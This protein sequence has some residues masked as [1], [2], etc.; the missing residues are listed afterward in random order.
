MFKNYQGFERMINFSFKVAAESRA[1]LLPIH[2]KLQVLT[3]VTAPTF[4]DDIFMRGTLTKVTIG[5][6]LINQPGNITSVQLAWEQDY[7]WEIDRKKPD[8]LILPHVLNVTV[9]MEAI[10]DFVPKYLGSKGLIPK[11][12]FTATGEALDEKGRAQ[13]SSAASLFNFGSRFGL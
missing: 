7:P 11:H 9:S 13:K 12:T 3:S 4:S 5:D 6:Y 1:D 2:R 10:H 8:T